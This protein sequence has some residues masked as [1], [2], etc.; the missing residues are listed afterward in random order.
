[1]GA[2]GLCAAIGAALAA[3]SS[4]QPW[5]GSLTVREW[6]RRES[7]WRPVHPPKSQMSALNDS[8][9]S[10]KQRRGAQCGDALFLDGRDLQGGLFWG[11]GATSGE[12]L[13]VL[14]AI[15]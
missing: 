8:V 3:A 11:Q 15:Q 10:T 5:A 12:P 4:H 1:M 2:A 7:R 9:P 13:L 14:L 6:V